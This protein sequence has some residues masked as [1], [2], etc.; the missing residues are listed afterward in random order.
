MKKT[1][2]EVRQELIGLTPERQAEKLHDYRS[3]RE[4]K[5][6]GFKNLTESFCGQKG[7]IE[8]T[9]EC[10]KELISSSTKLD[11]EHKEILEKVIEQNAKMANDFRLSNDERKEFA[12]K[13]NEFY[14]KYYWYCILKQIGIGVFIAALTSVLIIIIRG[15][16]NNGNQVTSRNQTAK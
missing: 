11:Q 16:R 1:E 14:T 9:L 3:H 7:Y 12:D 2:E 8:R 4:I 15:D 6:D 13:M 5:K 10:I